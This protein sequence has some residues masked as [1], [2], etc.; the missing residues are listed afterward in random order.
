[1]KIKSKQ[2][3]L[4]L[5]AIMLVL[6]SFCLCGCANV[7]FVTYHNDDGTIDEYVYLTLDEQALINHGYD[8]DAVKFEIKTSSFKQAF[9]PA[10]KP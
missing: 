8:I 5:L 6:L 2:F 1:M 9:I 10:I 7:N 4:S 3:N